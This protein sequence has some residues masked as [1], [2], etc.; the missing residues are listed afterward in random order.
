MYNL[1]YSNIKKLENLKLQKEETLIKEQ[2]VKEARNV[3]IIP[4]FGKHI[5]S[6]L[7]TFVLLYFFYLTYLYPLFSK[8]LVVMSV[9]V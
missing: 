5:S 1:M 6:M 3:L 9:C 7:V 2:E 4:T 8:F